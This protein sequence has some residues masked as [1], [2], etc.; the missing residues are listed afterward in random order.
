M[1]DT[2]IMYVWTVLLHTTLRLWRN[3]GNERPA[4]M[5]VSIPAGLEPGQW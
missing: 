2:V 1:G 3:Q 4:G 5:K